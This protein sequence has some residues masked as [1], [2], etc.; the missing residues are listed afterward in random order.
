MKRR[1]ADLLVEIAMRLYPAGAF[2]EPDSDERMS[3]EQWTGLIILHA[4]AVHGCEH[5]E[6]AR[7]ELG[8][9]GPRGERA[10]R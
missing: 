10:V 1:L 7:F 6:Q 5:T 3:G 4:E 9:L 2:F 8:M